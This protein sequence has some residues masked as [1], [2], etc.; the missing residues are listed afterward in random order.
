MSASGG[1]GARGDGRVVE[2][3]GRA[4]REASGDSDVGKAG[5]DLIDIDGAPG[6]SRVATVRTGSNGTAFRYALEDGASEIV[7]GTDSMT[8][9]GATIIASDV[10]RLRPK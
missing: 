9:G 10:K 2:R 1:G 8:M 3:R 5:G 4:R 6:T 7:I